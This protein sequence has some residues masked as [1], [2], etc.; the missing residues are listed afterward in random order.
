MKSR[1]LSVVVVTKDRP[2]DL[3]ELLDSLAIQTFLPLEVIVVDDSLGS[4]TSTIVSH[5]E[6]SFALQ[7]CQ[8]LYIKGN[9]T[10]LTEA[11]NLGVSMARGDSVVFLDDDVLPGPDALIESADFL[12]RF[13]NCLGFSASLVSQAGPDR[14]ERERGFANAAY[15]VLMLSYEKDDTLSVRRSGA[16]VF[17]RWLSRVIIAQRLSG[18]FMCYRHEVFREFQFDALLKRYSFME[19]LD[20]SYRVQTRYPGSL[21]VTPSILVVHKESP[22]VRFPRKSATYV[23]TVYWFY[24]FFK[25]IYS[26]SLVNLFA[27]L[28]ALNG[29]LIM[30]IL[31]A[32]P[33][34]QRHTSVLTLIHLVGG[35]YLSLSNLR[36]ILRGRLGFLDSRH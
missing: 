9:T 8:L 34:R 29:T 18:A 36:R 4:S 28:W 5:R 12:A 2:D 26:G 27:F 19:D 33:L 7:D 11:R 13:P 17:P 14:S 16:S 25:D 22:K 32:F 20:F 1:T 31:S 21:L 30:A 24:I 3:A 23:E 10:G 6:E 15:K 35:F